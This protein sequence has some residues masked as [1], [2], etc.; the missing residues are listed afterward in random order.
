[1]QAG[2]RNKAGAENLDW[3]SQ[4]RFINEAV[5][6]AL[7]ENRLVISVYTIKK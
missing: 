7:A 5:E 6:T 3:N 1:M 2:R 4:L